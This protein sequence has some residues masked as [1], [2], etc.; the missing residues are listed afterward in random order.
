MRG[1]LSTYL[2]GCVLT[3][4]LIFA[5]IVLVRTGVINGK[6]SRRK[7][8]LTATLAASLA[9]WFISRSHLVAEPTMFD[10]VILFAVLWFICFFLFWVGV[11]FSLRF[12]SP[13]RGHE[14]DFVESSILSMQFLESR[15][16]DGYVPQGEH[17]PSFPETESLAATTPSIPEAGSPTPPADGKKV[18][19]I[20][21]KRLNG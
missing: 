21:V 14:H 9:L 11:A 15:M 10:V 16:L 8:T 17:D 2:W 5:G 4:V 12:F 3:L 20:P 6:N 7:T 19:H 1:N 18:V 13:K